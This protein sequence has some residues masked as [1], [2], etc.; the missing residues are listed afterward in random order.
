MGIIVQAS[1]RGMNAVIM[2]LCSKRPLLLGI[3][4]SVCAVSSLAQEYTH[5]GRQARSLPNSFFVSDTVQVSLHNVLASQLPCGGWPKNVNFFSERE[6]HPDDDLRATIDND[7]TS[8]EIRFLFRYIE[9]N[10]LAVKADTLFRHATDAAC[11]G[12][13]Y[14]LQM[15]YP[16]GGFPQ[17]YP[18]ADHY[19]AHITFNDNAMVNVLKL[20]RQVARREYPFGGVST[21]LARL[22]E[23]S[24]RRGISCILRSQIVRDGRPTVWCQQ[25]HEVTLQPV[26]ARSFELAS[27]TA[28]ESVD[29]VELLMSL[30]TPSDSVCRAIEGAMDWFQHHSIDSLQRIDFIDTL[31]R[32]DYRMVTVPSDSIHRVWS[33]FYS[34]DTERPLFCG[35]DTIP[36][37]RVEDIEHERRNGY[38]WF[39]TSPQRLLTKY[40]K[41]K[42]RLR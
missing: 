24:F 4:C 37:N 9:H 29:I 2:K 26:P 18:R 10:M 39:V 20:L 8:T 12:L 15:Q 42:A 1:H 13:R 33:R 5:W 32:K 34:L 30:D 25:H 28:A 35:R 7:A 38:A 41:W 19:H 21:E 40:N 23:S 22:C 27:F 16:N 17:Y 14:L 3:V 11:R 6:E 36:R 31:G